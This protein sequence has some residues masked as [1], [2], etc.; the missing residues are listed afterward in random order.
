MNGLCRVVIVKPLRKQL[1]PELP[2]EQ[3]EQSETSG[4]KADAGEHRAQ[5]RSWENWKA[6]TSAGQQNVPE[7]VQAWLAIFSCGCLS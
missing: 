7:G 3:R 1:N 4:C 2:D 5:N 6:K